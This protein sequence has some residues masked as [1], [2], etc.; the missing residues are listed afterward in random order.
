LVKDDTKR[1]RNYLQDT[2]K[3]IEKEIKY[4]EVW[5]LVKKII[6]KIVMSIFKK[7]NTCCEEERTKEMMKYYE[8]SIMFK[9]KN[10]TSLCKLDENNLIN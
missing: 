7:P 8:F 4:N 6:W 1:N 9:V 10:L 5:S 3:N 2:K